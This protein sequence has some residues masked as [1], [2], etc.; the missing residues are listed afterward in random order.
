[1]FSLRMRCISGLVCVM[2]LSFSGVL[3]A[4]IDLTGIGT[5]AQS[6]GGNFR[7]VADDY[8]AMFWN[9]AGLVFQKGWHAGMNFTLVSQSSSY[10]ASISPVYYEKIKTIPPPVPAD[11]FAGLK[12]FSATYP[13]PAESSVPIVLVPSAG[14]YRS[15]G[16]LAAGIGAWAAFGVRARYDFIGTSKYNARSDFFK[17]E[18]WE[19][20]MKFIDIHP[21]VAYRVTDRLAVGA[22]F[23]L[24]IADIYLRKPAFSPMNPFI[25]NEKNV[26]YVLDYAKT[27]PEASQ[28]AFVQA[29]EEL[30]N[31]PRDHL[32]ADTYLEGSG[33]GVGG[34]LG[35]LFEPFE[36]FRIG[37]SLQYYAD[38]PLDGAATVTIYYPEHPEIRKYMTDSVM[39]GQTRYEGLTAYYERLQREGKIDFMDRYLLSKYGS[40]ET[41]KSRDHAS[42][43][44]NMPLPVRAGLGICYT[45]IPR[46]LLSAD[47]GWTKWSNWDVFLIKAEDGELFSSIKKDWKDVIR[48]GAGIEYDWTIF[49]CHGGFYTESR[50]AVVATMVP[51]NPDIGRRNVVSFGIEVPVKRFR[52][53]ANFEHTF[54]KDMTVEEWVLM[55]NGLDYQ[56][57]AGRYSSSMTNVMFGMDFD[58]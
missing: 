57:M 1:M 56:N 5:R 23:S 28:A 42:M 4:A 30:K 15:S 50:A 6:L 26:Q 32:L 39:I 24:I 46:M 38:I 25:N 49:R 33:I 14:V 40:G 48:M 19:D 35:I 41:E 18:D 9:P 52:F 10:L 45:G 34:N 58:I 37:A 2:V 17:G 16:K 51:T 47:I 22:G 11:T 31:S 12:Q 3:Q 7:A 8:S 53:H 44:C 20:D 43:T 29:L 55:E 27:L 21:T 54:M 36:T 13:Q